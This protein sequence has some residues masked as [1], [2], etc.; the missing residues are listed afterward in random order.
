MQATAALAA[1][2]AA[3]S[4]PCGGT[5]ICNLRFHLRWCWRPCKRSWGQQLPGSAPPSQQ[6]R[7]TANCG[8]A[9]DPGYDVDDPGPG[10]RAVR[11]ACCKPRKPAA[12][13]RPHLS[14]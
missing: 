5:L 3:A 9:G 12:L 14:S 7:A 13:A 8:R 6:R 2:A 4:N 1:V 10:K 11:Q